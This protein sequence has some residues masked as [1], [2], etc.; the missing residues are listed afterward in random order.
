MLTFINTSNR[1]WFNAAIQAILHVPQIANIMREESIFQKML[2]TKRKNAAMFAEELSK[3]AKTYWDSFEH[4][5]S[6]D[7]SNLL[8]IF[9]KINRNFAGKKQYDSTECFL[10][11]IE[12]L[13]TAFVSKPPTPLPETCDVDEW[14][15]YTNKFATTFISDVFLG[16]AKQQLTDGSTSFSHFTGITV[17]GNNSTIDKGIEEFMSDPDTGITRDITKPPLILPIIFQKAEEHGFV[18]YNT[19]LQVGTF[20]YDLFAILLHVN[21]CHWATLAK[22]PSGWNLFDDEKV[23]CIADI[24]AL[25]QRDAIMLLFKKTN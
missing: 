22:S 18:N 13:E 15:S 24:N 6:L 19:T 9:T 17:S 14:M 8:D 3:L 11:I 20:N 4:K 23:T 12:T 1:C 2:F 5:E 16:Q 25:I 21:N 10:K 7:I